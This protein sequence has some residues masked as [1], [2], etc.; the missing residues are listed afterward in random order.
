MKN[1]IS[2]RITQIIAA[3]SVATIPSSAFA[4]T[5][6]SNGGGTTLCTIAQQAVGY[7]NMAI[8]LIIG[9]A[10]VVFVFNIYR[11]FFMDRENNK[12]RGMYLLW[13]IIGFAVIVCFWGLVNL[14]AHSFNFDNSA[15]T[16]F[17]NM[18]GG[19]SSCG[20]SGS[21]AGTPLGSQGSLNTNGTSNV[22]MCGNTIMPSNGGGWT[23][24]CQNGVLSAQ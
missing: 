4:L 24:T 21:S 19:T 22:Q 17:G 20:S 8:E 1:I 10:I 6:G 9:L 5:T 12:E 16:T 18:F 3:V 13:S 14:V 2:R 23:Y 7:F 11:Y 15:P